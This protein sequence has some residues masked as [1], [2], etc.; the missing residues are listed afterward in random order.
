MHCLGGDSDGCCEAGGS[1]LT[2]LLVVAFSSSLSPAN[3]QNSY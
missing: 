2:F 1:G 3:I